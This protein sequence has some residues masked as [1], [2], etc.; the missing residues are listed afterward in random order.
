MVASP[1]IV[2][3]DK[4]S[5]GDE[6]KE[7]LSQLESL[8]YSNI[9]CYKTINDSINYLKT[10]KFEETVIIVSGSLY[11]LFIKEFKNNLNDIYI[12]PK[13]IIFTSNIK[14][15][16]Q[17]SEKDFINDPFYNKG[18]IHD[19]FEDIKNFILNQSNQQNI[20]LL[21][22]E[23]K[24]DLSFE[25]IDCEEKLLLPMFYKLLIQVTPNDNIEDFTR[26]LYNKYSKCKEM[27]ELL[28][29]IISMSH[30]PNE[31]LSKYYARA[32]TIESDFYFDLNKELRKENNK[33]NKY[34]PFIKVL[35]EGFKFE[36]LSLEP[37]TFLYRGTRLA[38]NEVNEIYDF[39]NTKK[40]NL[41]PGIVFSKSFLSFSKMKRVAE[42]FLENQNPKGDGKVKLSKVLFILENEK[43]IDNSLS[44][45]A[46]IERLSFHNEKEVLFFPFSSFEIKDIKK[47]E[48]KNRYEI[49][50]SYLG[51]NTYL[52]KWKSQ[53][54][55]LLSNKPTMKNSIS[56]NNIYNSPHNSHHITS[57]SNTSELL[58]NPQN[59][60]NIIKNNVNQNNEYIH[61]IG[62]L[63]NNNPILPTPINQPIH[64]RTTSFNLSNLPDSKFKKYL[65]DSGL[66]EPKTI[67]S[68]NN[69]EKLMKTYEVYKKEQI[70]LE[71]NKNNSKNLDNFGNRSS[72]PNYIIKR[73]KMPKNEERELIPLHLKEIN[74]Q[75]ETKSPNSS[76]MNKNWQLNINELN[77]VP[78]NKFN[79][80]AYNT[81][82]YNPTYKTNFIIGK[83]IVKENDINKHIRIINSFENFK[84]NNINVRVD[85]A[86]RYIN[87]NEIRNNCEIKIND[88]KLKKDFF[89]FVQMSQ[90]G[91]YKI[92]YS[93]KKN[94][95]KTDF[96]FANCTNLVALN[97][98]NFHSQDVTNMAYMFY[99]CTS[100]K[101]LEV[102]HLKTNKVNDMS[103]M[104]NGCEKLE[105]LDLSSFKTNNVFNMSRMF[106][107]CK[108]LK[109][110]DLY[111]FDTLK[112]NNMY[113]MFFECQSL[114]ELDLSSFNTQN[115]KNMSRM[116]S[117][118]RSLAKL[119][120]SNFA[121]INA[122]FMYNLF[123]ENSALK[124]LNISNF[125]TDNKANTESMFYGCVSLKPQ[126]I[127]CKRN[128]IKK[129]NYY[130]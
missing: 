51:K 46:E 102:L 83:I 23:D 52:E 103:N 31:L 84:S 115:V 8:G 119:D 18:G 6:I 62:N 130:E 69:T 67:E 42:G 95:T 49:K 61:N 79:Y 88:K 41:P 94:L 113:S 87:E 4:N 20:S 93:F 50:L 90:P 66:I 98:F 58:Q 112:V 120:I 12:I 128:V 73:I 17:N 80:S 43:N 21:K 121:T 91:E 97:L 22:R 27:E 9:K 64:N 54:K 45:H 111:S 60:N 11:N 30:I 1:K 38:E 78:M 40:E 116:F 48:N 63:S 107:S 72:S 122:E 106:Y 14:G 123:Y 65:F 105:Y 7:Y 57:F 92:E 118:C 26:N 76:I 127:I 59:I 53:T 71:K 32:Y 34:L 5:D 110:L 33:D 86:S 77:T 99:Q 47:N 74:S 10:I 81:V 96:L 109:R 2:W 89:Y 29:P 15:F 126:N 44:A 85:N 114:I 108:S 35:Y 82:N 68:N 3:L 24:G 124:T 25:R 19:Q 75:E 125:N 28:K 101:F 56:S 70:Q 117:G 104:F 37:N 13:I 100:L 39:F 16:K 129:V 36:T 55:I